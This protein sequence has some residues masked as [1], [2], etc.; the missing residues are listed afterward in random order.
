MKSRFL[1]LSVLFFLGCLTVEAQSTTFDLTGIWKNEQMRYEYHFK[2]DSSVI[3]SQSGY[4]A[5]I[6]SY[7]ID[8][9]KSPIWLDFT[10]KMGSREQVIPALLEIVSEDEI[11]I[12]QFPPFSN[13]PVEFTE[14][15]YTKIRF[16][17][18]K[19]GE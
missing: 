10:M 7:T 16:K 19:A 12:E 2:S 14:N 6:N 15:E 9:S 11:I 17:R 5:F 13:H 18:E 1:L 4:S 8:T 3:F